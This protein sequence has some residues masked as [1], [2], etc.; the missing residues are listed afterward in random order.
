MH[1]ATVN[2]INL[3]DLSLLLALT[4]SSTVS[5]VQDITLHSCS[6]QGGLQVHP[7]GSVVV[8]GVDL[9]DVVMRDTDAVITGEAS[10]Y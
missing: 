7:G 10:I 2:G 3:Q 8:A 4:D 1:V 9:Q 5:V 6:F